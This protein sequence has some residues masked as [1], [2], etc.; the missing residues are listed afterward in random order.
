[1][2]LLS[3]IH[4][5]RGM[6]TLNQKHSNTLGTHTM[7]DYDSIQDKCVV[8]LEDIQVC[9]QLCELPCGH[10]FHRCCISKMRETRQLKQLCP[11][12]K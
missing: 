3:F 2:F 6:K 1:M 11:L 10:V 8:C 9:E 4:R 5:L 7:K 12:C